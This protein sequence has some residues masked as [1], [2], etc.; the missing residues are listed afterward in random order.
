MTNK[1][2]NSHIGLFFMV[3]GKLL[4]HTCTLSDGEVYGDFINYPES[5]YTI[6][7]CEYAHIYGVDFDFFPRGRVIFNRVKNIY[8]LYHD[9]CIATE[10][11]ALRERYP[12]GKC[13]TGLDEHY[14]CHMCNENY[15]KV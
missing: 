11:D 12:V 15:V 13:V 3:N 2:L 7:Q 10:A 14:K 8:L 6:W 1:T 9:L 5:H 4:L